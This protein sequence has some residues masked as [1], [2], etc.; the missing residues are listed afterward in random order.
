MLFQILGLISCKSS[1]FTRNDS[2]QNIS[3]L[4]YKPIYPVTCDF[5]SNDSGKINR[6][7]LTSLPSETVL[8]SILDVNVGGNVSATVAPVNLTSK[9]GC[10]I[11]EV[12][13]DYI[14]YNVHMVDIKKSIEDKN[15][16]YTNDKTG[17]SADLK[18]SDDI[19]TALNNLVVRPHPESIEYFERY[20]PI[21][22]GVGVR[23]KA[24]ITTTTA[25]VEIGTL[26]GIAAGFEAKKLTGTLEVQTLGLSGK[27]ITLILPLPS[28]INRTTIQNALMAMASIKSLIYDANDVVVS[29]S[30]VGYVLPR[31]NQINLY[32]EILILQQ[33][34]K[35][36]IQ[37]KN[38]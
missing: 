35:N 13:L 11:Y 12:V 25:G 23:L 6:E 1:L 28:E 38:R 14:K 37:I 18:E 9:A 30:V 27:A 20:I 3:G 19:F 33:I 29:P 8:L 7:L 15:L 2:V 5:P 22:Y 32:L 4:I 36:K 31:K 16:E 21:Y 24:T 34:I 10:N 26:Y 17:S